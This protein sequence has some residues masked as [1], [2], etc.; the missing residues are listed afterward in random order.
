MVDPETHA[1]LSP[2]RLAELFAAQEVEP[3][4]Q[5]IVYCGGAIVECSSTLALELLGARDVTVYDGSLREW[6]RDPTRPLIVD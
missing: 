3:E 6:A 1:F 4:G 2:G 5:T